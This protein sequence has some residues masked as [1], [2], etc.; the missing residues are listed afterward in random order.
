[1]VEKGGPS[2][3]LPGRC[4][5]DQRLQAQG[6]D[7]VLITG[8]VANVCCESTARDASNVAYRVIMVAHGNAAVRDADLNATLHTFYRNVGDVGP[9]REL[10]DG[11][12][13]SGAPPGSTTPS[14]PRLEARPHRVIRRRSRIARS[15]FE[16]IRDA[17]MTMGNGS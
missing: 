2:A 6:V 3:F 1:M 12:P 5:P 9:T 7:T 11:T 14:C 15:D 17:A 13:T 4:D 16:R 8:T 10:L